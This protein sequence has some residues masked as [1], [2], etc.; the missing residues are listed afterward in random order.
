MLCPQAVK[1]PIWE[2][3]KLCGGGNSSGKC[4]SS[5]VANKAASVRICS[6]DIRSLNT[7]FLRG[8][9][10]CLQFSDTFSWSNFHCLGCPQWWSSDVLNSQMKK[11][12]ICG[13]T[14]AF[15]TCTHIK[16][17]SQRCV[18]NPRRCGWKTGSSMRPREREFQFV[19]K[20]PML[21]T[22]RPNLGLG[23]T[24][25]SEHFILRTCRSAGSATRGR[26]AFYHSRS[27]SRRNKQ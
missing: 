11:I 5:L 4:V 15:W 26:Q 1:T 22:R 27:G 16:K 17:R 18:S 7:L 19:D 10:I 3:I 23:Y 25:L 12:E 13:S 9:G 24:Q 20:K 2:S 21:E 8:A 6:F 14:T